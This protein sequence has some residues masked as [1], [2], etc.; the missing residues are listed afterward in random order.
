MGSWPTTASEGA[1]TGYVSDEFVGKPLNVDEDLNASVD[2]EAGR[3][4]NEAWARGQPLLGRAKE[5][6]KDVKE[7]AQNMK[8]IDK[9]MDAIDEF[10]DIAKFCD[11]IASQIPSIASLASTRILTVAPET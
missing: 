10:L 4:A 5:G 11:K 8:K 7:I 9:F 6:Q 2:T 1:I 3:S